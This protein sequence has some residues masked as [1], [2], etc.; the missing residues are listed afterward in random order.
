V[1][2]VLTDG[3]IAASVG[4]A[5]NKCQN[6]REVTV[7]LLRSLS[8]GQTTQVGYRH[9]QYNFRTPDLSGR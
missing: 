9:E 5:R 2:G 1:R 8:S 6:K 3:E 7:G 4:A